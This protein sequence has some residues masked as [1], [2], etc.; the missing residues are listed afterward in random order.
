MTQTAYPQPVGCQSCLSHPFPEETATGCSIKAPLELLSFPAA[1]CSS[2]CQ[3][4]ECSRELW[5][6]WSQETLHL[7]VAL[8]TSG[9]PI[10]PGMS[11]SSTLRP[12]VVSPLKKKASAVLALKYLQSTLASSVG[13]SE[14][15]VGSSERMFVLKR[16]GET[17]FDCKHIW[18]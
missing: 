4:E 1:H 7:R 16:K 8:G 2:Y 13:S 5:G 11:V 3:S 9:G 14:Q 12:S 6:L 10:L 17:V 18:G 15:E